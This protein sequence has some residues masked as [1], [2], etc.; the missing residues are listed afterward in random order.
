MKTDH[1]RLAN[2]ILETSQ[3]LREWTMSPQATHGSVALTRVRIAT[4]K[5]VLENQPVT[6][7]ELAEHLRVAPPTVTLLIQGLASNGLIRRTSG[8]KDR[9]NIRV[10]ITPKGRRSLAIGCREMYQRLH[11]VLDRLTVQERNQ[12]ERMLTRLIMVT[13]TTEK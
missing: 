6:M 7:K 8:A 5:F 12:L 1:E 3:R 4:L 10:T 11:L 13:P 2:L 9:R